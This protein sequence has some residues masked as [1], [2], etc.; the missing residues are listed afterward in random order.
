M[1]QGKK[2]KETIYEYESLFLLHFSH[3]F[4]PYFHGC[5]FDVSIPR[6]SV[7]KTGDQGHARK[8]YAYKESVVLIYWLKLSYY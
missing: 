4:S 7:S 1:S 8:Y 5:L 6:E 2:T 3:D